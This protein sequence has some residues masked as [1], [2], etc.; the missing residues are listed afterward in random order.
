MITSFAKRGAA[1]NELYHYGDPKWL[2]TIRKEGLKAWTFV[3][4]EGQMSDLR[5]VID[6]ALLPNR[7]PRTLIR[8]DVA[9]LRRAGYRIPTLKQV[10][11]V[12]EDSK[13]A[14]KYQMPG[15]GLEILFPY[16]IPKRF[17]TVIDG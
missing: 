9:E 1:G 4:P 6:L 2:G 8:V 10:G 5:A 16:K 7:G 3:T 12:V 13:W 15:G 14:R 17:I 11:R